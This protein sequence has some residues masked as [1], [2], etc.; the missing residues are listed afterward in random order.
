MKPKDTKP[1]ESS[2]FLSWFCAHSSEHWRRYHSHLH[3]ARNA[4]NE[5]GFTGTHLRRTILWNCSNGLFRWLLQ[6]HIHT[7]AIYKFYLRRV[8]GKG[9]RGSLIKLTF[10]RLLPRLIRI[11]KHCLKYHLLSIRKLSTNSLRSRGKKEYETTVT[12]LTF[13]GNW[14]TIKG[15]F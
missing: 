13:F 3:H 14:L 7:G 8:K 15:K 9:R 10:T 11:S 1:A 4:H 12:A 2:D 6:R 5:V